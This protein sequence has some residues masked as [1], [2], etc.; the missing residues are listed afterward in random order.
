MI[1]LYR[2]ANAKYAM[3]L[4]GEGAR[5]YGGR[6]NGKGNAMVYTSTSIS[7]ALVEILVHSISFEKLKEI[8][9]ISIEVPEPVANK[10]IDIH[11]LKK[12]W[13]EDEDYTGYIG[14]EFIRSSNFL[15]MK[16]PSAVVFEEQNILINPRH[17]DF[18]KVKITSVKPF[19]L[20][21]RLFKRKN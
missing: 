15:L 5:L 19:H 12:D 6:W 14:D 4:S 21:S 1:K 16:V 11:Q 13:W 7:L 3:D 9:L 17:K 8:H 2:F 20:D 10:Q 18:Q